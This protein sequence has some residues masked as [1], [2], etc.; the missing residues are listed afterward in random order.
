MRIYSRGYRGH[1]MN[2]LY[3]LE[4]ITCEKADGE[5]GWWSMT[6]SSPAMPQS[7]VCLP[8][9]VC[10]CLTLSCLAD[11]W[12]EFSDQARLMLQL[13]M[14]MSKLRVQGGVCLLH[15]R[16]PA[17]GEYFIW[18]IWSCGSWSHWSIL[19]LSLIMDLHQRKTLSAIILFLPSRNLSFL[20]FVEFPRHTDIKEKL[21]KN[22]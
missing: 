5:Q 2:P 21:M 19:Q 17:Q 18:G 9:W 6:H 20:L 8:V 11:E 4:P 15:A 14:E 12:S 13:W 10:V 7:P 16:L 3:V 1:R 22:L